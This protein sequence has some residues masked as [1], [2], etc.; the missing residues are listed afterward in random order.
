MFFL[1]CFIMWACESE[2][3][4]CYLRYKE[5]IVGL[6]SLVIICSSK[7]ILVAN[8]SL[9][10]FTVWLF[11]LY[12]L[13]I[14]DVV[15]LTMESVQRCKTHGTV[16]KYTLCQCHLTMFICTCLDPKRNIQRIITSRNS[17]TF[18]KSYWVG[19][20]AWGNLK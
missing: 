14:H 3:D 18:F 10:H 12:C 15:Y 1:I 11:V 9:M 17:V 2:F 16:G 6:Q 5:I 7:T 4:V 20:R 19:K 8:I 13:Q